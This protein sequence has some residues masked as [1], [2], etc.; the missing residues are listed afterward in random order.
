MDE[1]KKKLPLG[2]RK[3]GNRYEGRLQHDYH[4]YYVHAATIT[5]TKKKLTELRFKLEHGGFVAKEKITLDEWFNTWI[6]EYKENDVKKGTVISYQN[7]YAYYVKNELGKMSIVDI[8]GEHIQRLYNKLLEDKLSLSSLKVISA[9]LS[10]CFKRAAMNGLIE[11]NPVS[12]ASLPRKKSKKER[13]VLSLK[14]QESFMKYASDSYLYQMFALL[15][16]TGMRGGEARGLK[17]SDVDKTKKVIHVRRTLKY[18]AGIG[19]FE[20]MP[21]TEASLRDI[22]MT[23]EIE[24][25]IEAQ[26]KFW[27]AHKVVK[28]DEYIF[29]IGDGTPISRER[30]QGEID[31]II[32]KMQEDGIYLQRFTPHCLRHTFATRAIENGM[33]P[34]ILKTIMGHSSLSMTM[35]LYSHV[36]PDKKAAEMEKIQ[37]AFGEVDRKKA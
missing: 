26:K 29:H 15:L 13:R 12:L 30:L 18:E 4:T 32:R 17:Y 28:L 1:A 34:Q 16:R 27:Q 20:D 24:A 22:P 10:G 9:V 3:R 5:E 19:F 6:K 35:D 2:I 23:K 7:Y 33:E 37:S 36:L 11:R 25:I 14:E 8:R 21:K 31:R